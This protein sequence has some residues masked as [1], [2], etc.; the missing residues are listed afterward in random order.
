[1]TS[2]SLETLEL[3]WKKYIKSELAIGFAVNKIKYYHYHAWESSLTIIHN[4]CYVKW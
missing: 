2:L 4:N 3:E 1:M